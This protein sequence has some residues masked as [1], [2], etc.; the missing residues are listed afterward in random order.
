MGADPSGEDQPDSTSRED[1]EAAL[2]RR[3]GRGAK[4]T[5][6]PGILARALGVGG[7]QQVDTHTVDE[8][9]EEEEKQESTKTPEVLIRVRTATLTSADS[10]SVH[11]LTDASAAADLL[12][13]KE[14]RFS[15]N[16]AGA[17]SAASGSH[18]RHTTSSSVESEGFHSIN[19]EDTSLDDLM[20]QD[21][22]QWSKEV[23]TY[24]CI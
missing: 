23:R 16:P 10:S 13:N 18:V 14:Q 17:A 2:L 3:T 4:N 21:W 1:M 7:K 19:S 11:T 5:S 9:R 24:V 6:A 12:S 8:R 22:S 20:H 15:P